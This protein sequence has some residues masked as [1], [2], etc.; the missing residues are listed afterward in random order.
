MG[1]SK[2]KGGEN[3]SNEPKQ[4]ITKLLHALYDGMGD[5][6]KTPE[7]RQYIKNN[8]L[9]TY[10]DEVIAQIKAH[11]PAYTKVTTK[12]IWAKDFKRYTKST[13]K[14]F[15]VSTPSNPNVWLFDISQTSGKE[16]PFIYQ[17]ISG[18]A[19]HY[20]EI[21]NCL[22]AYSERP[23]LVQEG[24]SYY[25][26]IGQDSFIENDKIILRPALSEQQIIFALVREIIRQHQASTVVCEAASYMVCRHL[27]INTSAFTF[28][29]L[30][31]Y[32]KFDE[33]LKAL[34]NNDTQETIIREAEVLIGFLNAN[35]PFLQDTADGEAVLEIENKMEETIEP[36]TEM[37]P[38]MPKK[39]LQQSDDRIETVLGID[40]RFV[41]I[42]KEFM[43]IRPDKSVT[44]EMVRDYNYFD[45]NMFFLNHAVA[46][47]L[48]SMGREIYILHKDNTEIRAESL[49]DI[50]N[51]HGLFGIA[52]DDWLAMQAEMA[53]TSFDNERV[54][55]DRWRQL[56]TKEL[57][58]KR[59]G[60]R[61]SE[62][63]TPKANTTKTVTE[64]ETTDDSLQYSPDGSVCVVAD[65]VSYKEVENP[66]W[67]KPAL[68][69]LVDEWKYKSKDILYFVK[70]GDTEPSYDM[71][72]INRIMVNY[73]ANAIPNALKASVVEKNGQRTC[74]VKK[75]V[76]IMCE[77][78]TTEHIARA[79]ERYW[80]QLK[81]PFDIK[82]LF[83]EQ[84]KRQRA[85]LDAQSQAKRP[86]PDE[87]I[88]RVKALSAEQSAADDTQCKIGEQELELIHIIEHYKNQM[89]AKPKPQPKAE[90]IIPALS[91]I[92]TKA[93]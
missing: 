43:A 45:V 36:N 53:K 85:K 1:Y 87:R 50:N 30:L 54:K 78:F 52:K 14:P 77:Y 75:A 8:R 39:P 46:V 15:S 60:K 6:T 4:H 51:H 31:E 44:M 25:S 5:M 56:A 34:K 91:S 3:I 35:L 64:S 20:G 19:L 88:R 55:I 28:G 92:K 58:P 13:E 90:S 27:G 57:N 2:T 7:Y 74:E 69:R 70:Q 61:F 48:F 68:A 80:M 67:I 63:D 86:S 29:Y 66:K 47:R 21:L 38:P 18:V 17:N 24:S 32:I 65:D 62:K 72:K 79:L 59:G 22:T 10:P 82:T 37:P 33:S 23:V 12:D 9:F 42:I 11:N 40:F 26:G 89:A 81:M 83:A 76:L 71:E 41:K 16:V 84:F 93:R 73:C 49:D